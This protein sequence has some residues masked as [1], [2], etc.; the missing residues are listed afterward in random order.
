MKK[1]EEKLDMLL[2]Q[3]REAS[4]EKD[5]KRLMANVSLQLDAIKRGY[6]SFRDT[7]CDLIKQYPNMIQEE[8]NTYRT[9]LLNFFSILGE[10][11]IQNDDELRQKLIE[12]A[13]SMR[14]ILKVV[15]QTE[16]GTTFYVKLT[17]E[18]NANNTVNEKFTD[19]FE[20]DKILDYNDLFN[21]ESNQ[22]KGD[23][24]QAEIKFFL[25]NLY[26]PLDKFENTK[27]K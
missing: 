23:D 9:A 19:D 5:L 27:E 4:N 15:L 12:S 18:K 2:D 22:N 21:D 11:E 3:L 14:N 25:K 7:Q 26:I 8:L 24:K 13:D 16:N 17:N 6:V 10:N 20:G 1:R